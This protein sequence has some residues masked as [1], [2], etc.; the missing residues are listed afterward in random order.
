M[1]RPRLGVDDPPLGA[2]EEDGDE[3]VDD[4]LVAA[5]PVGE[6]PEKVDSI[7]T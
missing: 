7:P 6:E 3:D 5:A 2:G 1:T 4:E